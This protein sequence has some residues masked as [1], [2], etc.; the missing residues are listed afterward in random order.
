MVS[1]LEYRMPENDPAKFARSP[2]LFSALIGALQ[3]VAQVWFLVF[4]P[5]LYFQDYVITS[6][7]F[8]MFAIPVG[9]VVIEMVLLL[10]FHGLAILATI[11]IPGEKRK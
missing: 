1:S 8:L 3:A 9:I 2:L 4:K 5:S 6:I 11:L 7:A 10:G